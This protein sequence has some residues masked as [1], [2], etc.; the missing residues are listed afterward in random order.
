VATT[1]VP[2]AQDFQLTPHARGVPVSEKDPEKGS[3]DDH[4]AYGRR[5]WDL[6]E[7]VVFDP[8]PSSFVK[9]VVL[10]LVLVVVAWAL[11]GVQL[12]A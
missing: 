3:S 4:R 1:F 10:I 5:A 8:N 6:V 12:P 11:Q 2:L 7:K 9:L